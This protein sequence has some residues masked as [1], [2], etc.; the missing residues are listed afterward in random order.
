MANSTAMRGLRVFG[1]TLGAIL[2]LFI[3]FLFGIWLFVDPNAYKGRIEQAV[4]QSTGRTLALSGNIKLSVFP[5]IALELGPASL[6][7]PP[8][9]GNE[10][11]ASLQRAA[12]S[13]RLLPLLHEQLQ[14]GHLEVDGLDLSL[15]TNAQGQGNWALGGTAARTTSSSGKTST[16]SSSTE[17]PEVAGVVIKNSR[18]SY[19]DEVADH[20]TVNVGRVAPG[21][22]VPVGFKLDLIQSPGAKPIALAGKFQ[23][24]LASDAYRLTGLD[25]QL[26]NSTLRG[27]AALSR[28][29]TEA[30]SFTLAIDH[31]NLDQYLQHGAPAP[32]QPPGPRGPPTELPTDTLKTLQ[33]NGQLTIGNTQLQGITMTQVRVGLQSD[34]GLTRID[35]ISATLYG[36]SVS[37]QVTLDARQGTPV[38]K[39]EQTING[40]DVK[41]LLND[42]AHTQRLSG[43]GNL[44]INLSGQGKDTDALIRTLNGRVTMSLA[45]GAITGAD[46]WFEVRRALA[47]FQRQAAPTGSDQGQ[48][49]F[50]TFKTSAD[51]AQGI[52]TTKDLTI[53]S[54]DLRL[55][56]EGTANLITQAMNYRLQVVI[57]GTPSANTTAAPLLTVPVDVTGT[58]SNYKVR[59]DL[60]ALA[61]Q[62]LQNLQK[63]DKGQLEQKIPGL[64]KGL[65]NRGSPH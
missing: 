63:L 45:N 65:L 39:L 55:T 42:F 11:F 27:D 38:M 36:G 6:G 24:A 49:K 56:G 32:K 12:L 10:P 64:L 18:F 44:S 1:I 53:A 50:D 14:I 62:N 37:G 54:Q 5:A 59:P 16:T 15:K 13:V 58:F 2:V 29:A 21:E 51:V 3:L 9:F 41:P 40:V 57:G 61:K 52:A 8:G 23:L 28:S 48:T 34:R 60:S 35:P 33:M 19:Q 46:I 25:M 26:D 22:T 47:L 30:I 43:R 17:L 4:Q 7:N 31:I 20:V